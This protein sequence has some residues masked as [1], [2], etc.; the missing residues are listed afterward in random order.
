M[1]SLLEA[2]PYL[3]STQQVDLMQ[4]AAIIGFLIA[5]LGGG[6]LS[7]MIKNAIVRRSS[8]QDIWPEQRLISLVPGML[9]GPA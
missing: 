6:K 3:F 7:D 2:P 1:S 4:V 8:G 9:F 5:C